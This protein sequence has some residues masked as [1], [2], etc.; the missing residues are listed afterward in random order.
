MQHRYLLRGRTGRERVPLQH[1]DRATEA[2]G[3]RV[4]VYPAQDVPASEDS[5]SPGLT[6]QY[7]KGLP[8]PGH[9]KGVRVD[10]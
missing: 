9:T 4:A 6:G 10:L 8:V 2:G 5:G 3:D 7:L 1:D